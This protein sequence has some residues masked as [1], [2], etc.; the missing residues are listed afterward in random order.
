MVIRLPGGKA[1]NLEGRI[2]GT[3]IIGEATV[4]IKLRRVVFIWCRFVIEMISRSLTSNYLPLP[5]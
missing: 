2:K 1:R 5:A 4:L 3:T